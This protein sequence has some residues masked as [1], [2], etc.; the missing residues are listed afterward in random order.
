MS[1]TP[2]LTKAGVEPSLEAK[3]C[4]QGHR[5]LLQQRMATLDCV[6][7]RA[8]WFEGRACFQRR[9]CWGNGVQPSRVL[10]YLVCRK[11]LSQR[12]MHCLVCCQ[13]GRRGGTFS[14]SLPAPR[15]RSVRNENV[16]P[17][18]AGGPQRY[19]LAVRCWNWF[20]ACM[21]PSLGLKRYLKVN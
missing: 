8:L 14:E 18:P 19:Q 5:G 15:F 9:M 17:P 4:L 7:H 2:P 16:A 1:P 11:L 13:K 12:G 10:V 6:V 21:K 20:F 3:H